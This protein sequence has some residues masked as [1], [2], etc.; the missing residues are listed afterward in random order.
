M[1][2]ACCEAVFQSILLKAL[3]TAH[4]QLLHSR[5]GIPRKYSLIKNVEVAKA[6]A[7]VMAE[8]KINKFKID[9]AVPAALLEEL[10]RR[11]PTAIA[12]MS[13]EE[14]KVQAWK[15]EV[16]KPPH[17]T[18][19][20]SPLF[21]RLRKA[22]RDEMNAKEE[23]ASVQE[24]TPTDEDLRSLYV[25]DG[26]LYGDSGAEDGPALIRDIFGELLS[27]VPLAFPEPVLQLDCLGN[28]I[29]TL[30]CFGQQVQANNPGAFE[31]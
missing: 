31:N 24:L 1:H 12:R 20:D 9:E 21:A 13:F 10:E 2:C 18:D 27:A 30:Q 4:H 16:A 11:V 14:L 22:V 17:P 7:R 19:R 6:V 15:A 8:L 28:L 25:P 29:N 3:A 23:N 5:Q 26:E